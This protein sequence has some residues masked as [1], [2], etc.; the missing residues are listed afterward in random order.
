MIA[1]AACLATILLSL[2]GLGLTASVA[3]PTDGSQDVDPKILAFLKPVEI[4]QGDNEL[5]K[6]LKE[7]HNVAVRLLDERINEY[8]T[9]V[10]DASHVFDAARLTAEAK[11]ELTETNET[12]IATLEQVLDIAKLIESHLERQIQQGFGSRGDMERA[13]LGRLSVEVEIIR[14]KAK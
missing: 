2:A 1:S 7:R 9:G 11:L 5:Q 12:R 10:R 13:R 3:A 14:A 8:K 4:V 6:K